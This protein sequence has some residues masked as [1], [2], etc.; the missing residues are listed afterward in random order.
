MS[1][2]NENVTN[3]TT[4]TTPAPDTQSN[5]RKTM[6]YISKRDMKKLCENLK[7]IG[8]KYKVDDT[9]KECINDILYIVQTGWTLLNANDEVIIQM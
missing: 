2:T 9:E 4:E 3:T 6:K 8:A 1:K 5:V 7:T